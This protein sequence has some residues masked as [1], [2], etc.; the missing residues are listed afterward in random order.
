[1]AIYWMS[2]HKESLLRRSWLFQT[3]SLLSENGGLNVLRG[4]G[5]PVATMGGWAIWMRPGWYNWGKVYQWGK[6]QTD[7]LEDMDVEQGIWIGWRYWWEMGKMA[8][9]FKFWVSY[10]GERR[11]VQ[12]W[13][14]IYRLQTIYVTD[15]VSDSSKGL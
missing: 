2:S 12:K 7:G 11:T 15:I 5:P 9:F 13:A 3:S 10:K 1:M 4:R 14:V 8:C 6:G